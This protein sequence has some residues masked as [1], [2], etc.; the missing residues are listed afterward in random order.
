VARNADDILTDPPPP[1]ADMRLAYG[2]EPLQFGDLRESESETLVVVLHG[3]SWK[4]TYNLIHLGHLCILLRDAGLTTFNLE[5]RRVGDPGGGWPG[6][7][8][9]VVLALEFARRLA[10]RI[11]LV[12]HSAGGHLALL[13]SGRTGLPVVALAAVCDPPTWRNDAVGAFFA[14]EAR[15]EGSPLARLPIDAEQRL[16]HGTS[17]DVV[18]FDQ[19]ARYAE[20]AG[21]N[22]RLIRL[23]G[24]RHFEPI[25]PRSPESEVVVRVIGELAG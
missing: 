17:D 4:A 18:P 8:N 13:A 2:S 3:G 20:T 19:S 6:S 7:L 24:A 5:Y 1:A 10:R 9:D 25:D 23:D 16:V 12:G 11:V 14:G 21:A 22:A 15:P